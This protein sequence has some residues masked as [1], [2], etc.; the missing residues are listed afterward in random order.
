MLSRCHP[1]S[2]L[3]E[4]DAMLLLARPRHEHWVEQTGKTSIHL[5]RIT[6]N[7]GVVGLVLSTSLVAF[8]RP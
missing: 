4:P 7:L 3:V 8:F 5:D 6:A 2:V 1:V